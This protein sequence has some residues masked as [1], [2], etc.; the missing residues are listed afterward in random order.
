MHLFRQRKP[1]VGGASLY[2]FDGFLLICRLDQAKA[3]FWIN[4]D[5]IVRVDEAVTADQLGVRLTESL[6]RTQVRVPDPSFKGGSG[7]LVEPMVKAAK[8]R[9]YRSFVRDTSLVHL[10][11]DGGVFTV[12]PTR[13]NG[14]T[15]PDRGFSY[16]S[17]L[18]VSCPPQELGRAAM[19]GLA[20][21]IAFPD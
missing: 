1:Q 7:W 21:A 8:R 10:H 3:G 15:G 12:T 5:D 4:T 14:P 20:Q 2:R 11:R 13:N 9:S 17:E 19:A 16:L 6:D 18:A